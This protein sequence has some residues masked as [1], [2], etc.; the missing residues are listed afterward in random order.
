MYEA[1]EIESSQQGTLKVHVN[2]YALVKEAVFS[3]SMSLCLCHLD[4]RG[5]G[6][7]PC[8][9]SASPNDLGAL[10]ESHRL[11]STWREGTLCTKI[12]GQ[13]LKWDQTHLI[14]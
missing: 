9:Q 7:W 5:E 12:N 3:G 13:A 10:S 1:F 8:N 4:A 11:V 6:G 14:S 2:Q